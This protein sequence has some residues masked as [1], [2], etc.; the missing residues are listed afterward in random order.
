MSTL[1]RD[2]VPREA[3]QAHDG[4]VEME[5]ALEVFLAHRIRLFRIAH[6][7]TGDVASAED[8]VQEA[9]VRWQRTDRTAIKSPGAFLTTATTHLAINLIQTAR[10]RHETTAEPPP[11]DLADSG[12]D[13]AARVEQ[14]AAVQESLRLML[15]RLTRPELTAYLLRK[16]FDHRY[17]DIASLLRTSVANTRQLVRRARLRL[18]GGQDHAVDPAELHLLTTAFLRAAGTGDFQPLERLL[19]DDAARALAC[20]GTH[21]SPIGRGHRPMARFA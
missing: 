11:A 16:G 4:V 14:V 8:V 3:A 1:A 2:I 10:H 9:W 15:A 19:V 20:A 12:Q 21:R 6:R 18:D 13:P 7:I 17:A 5:R